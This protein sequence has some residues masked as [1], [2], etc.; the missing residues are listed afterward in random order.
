VSGQALDLKRSVHIIRRHRILVGALAVLGLLAGAGY[1]VIKPPLF[2]TSTLVVVPYAKGFATANS[3]YIATQIVI[4]HSDPVLVNALPHVG[5][6]IS[7]TTLR[8][9]VK[10]AGLTSN[11]ISITAEGRTADQAEA[12]ANAVGA[13]Y[14]AYLNSVA[15]PVGRIQ[16]RILGKA[17]PATGTSLY[18]R[19]AETAGIGLL[20]GVLIGLILALA[21]GRGDRRLRERDQIADSI[22]IPVLA[23]VSAEHPRDAA[24]WAKLLESYEPGLVDAW[25]LR[26]ALY[27][28]G[29]AGMNPASSTG[30]SGSPDG[31]SSSLTVLSLASDQT[32]VALGPQLAAF[33]ASLGIRTALVVAPQQ[34]ENVTATLYAA[35]AAVPRLRSGN[36]LVAV[37]DHDNVGLLTGVALT[38]AVGVV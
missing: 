30:T 18:V 10:V 26:K 1:T 33:A 36:L 20:P 3:A 11:V 35:C 37:S 8:D 12:T 23:S 16:A 34:N 24:G 31:S 17:T 15:S 28:M 9:R 21:I 32:A 14:L 22:G 2:T 19:M 38:V 27:Q 25:H 7:L 13:S 5:A 4:A 6:T 29:L